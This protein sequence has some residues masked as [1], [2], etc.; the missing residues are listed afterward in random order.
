MPKRVYD[1]DEIQKQIDA[2]DVT[3]FGRLI[4]QVIE[5]T[6]SS[7]HWYLVGRVIKEVTGWEGEWHQIEA[8]VKRIA[9]QK[10]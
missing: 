10:G 6:K 5:Q 8:L 9:E 3:Q 2:I 4:A 7:S 1:P